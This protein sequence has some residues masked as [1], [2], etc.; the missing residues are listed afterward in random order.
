MIYELWTDGSGQLGPGGWAYILR[1]LDG[2]GQLVR[3]AEGYGGAV[4]TT[5]NRMELTAALMGLRALKRPTT[6]TVYTDS[7][8]LANAFRQDW[9][10]KWDKKGWSKIKNSDLWRE[11]RAVASKHTVTFKWVRGHS[12]NELNERCDALAGDARQAVIEAL[13][14][15]TVDALWFPVAA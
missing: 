6:I 14:S 11:L 4:D 12:G 13:Q 3:E 2:S 5:N 7:E 8:Y 1:A 15:E 10:S 9:F